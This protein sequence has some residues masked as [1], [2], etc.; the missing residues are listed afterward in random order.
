M[1]QVH[2]KIV[3]CLFLSI[4]LVRSLDAEQFSNALTPLIPVEIPLSP[5]EQNFTCNPPKK[6][7]TTI[8]TIH[9]PCEGNLGGNP[10]RN[11]HEL[12]PSDVSVV[13]ALGDSISTGVFAKNPTMD[14]CLMRKMPEYRGVSWSIGGD[15]N[16]SYLLTLPNILKQYNPMVKG[17][18]TGLGTEWD[19]GM[20]FNMAVS[21]AKSSDLPIQAMRLVERLRNDPS[22]NYSEDWKIV[23]LFIGGNDLCRACQQPDRYSARNFYLH[24]KTTV[25]ILSMIPRTYVNIAQVVDVYELRNL[26][27]EYC[28]LI[29]AIFKVLGQCLCMSNSSSSSIHSQYAEALR[30]LEEEYQTEDRDDFS[31]VVQPFFEQI[32]LS[33]LENAPSYFT[34]DCFHFSQKAHA[35]IALLLWNNMLQPEGEKTNSFDTQSGI[36]C[37]RENQYFYTHRNSHPRSRHGLVVLLITVTFIISL[38]LIAIASGLSICKRQKYGYNVLN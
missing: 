26:N 31:V 8:Y 33:E 17:Y 37:A 3:F 32:K 10:A 24:L 36:I 6:L 19:D 15:L 38:T 29:H 28:T 18:S 14:I 21:G 25:D 20:G 7:T 2:G 27:N 34:G 1:N 35:I 11:V 23:T 30:K 9:F 4:S 13:A 16:I 5:Q 12:K 22:I